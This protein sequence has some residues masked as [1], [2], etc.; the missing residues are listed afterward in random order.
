MAQASAADG[1]K[2]FPPVFDVSSAANLHHVAT[3]HVS[4]DCALDFDTQ[5]CAGSVTLSLTRHDL[6]AA[7]VVLDVQEIK[8]IKCRFE[9]QASDAA[10]EIKP[11]S[12]FGQALHVTL[13]PTADNELKLTIQF[14]GGETAG[15][16]WLTPEQTAGKKM[17]FVY[18]QGQACLNRSWFPCQDTPALKVTYDATVR[19]KPGFQVVMSGLPDVPGKSD[20]KTGEVGAVEVDGQQW[21]EF[22]Y[23]QPVPI[24]VYLVALAAGDLA[25]AEIGPRS[26]VWAEPSVLPAA[27]REFSEVTEKYL[28]TAESLFGPYVWGRYDL[29]VMPPSFPYGGMENPNLTFVTPTLLAGDRSLTD[30]I[31]H[32]IS[33]SWFGNLVTN[34][35]WNDF[36]LNEGFTTYAQRRICALATSPEHACLE[37]MS[38]IKLLHNDI[39]T[40]PPMLTKLHIPLEPGTDPDDTYCYTPYEKGFCFLSYLASKV[41]VPEFD[42]F[43]KAYV[44]QF[45]N[46]CITHQQAL[47]FFFEKFPEQRATLPFEPGFTFQEWL[48][49]AG[50]PPFEPDF[51]A[52]EP[53]YRPAQA[54]ADQWIAADPAVTSAP[55]PEDWRTYQFV[56]FLDKLLDAEPL[57]LE[58]MDQLD[59][60]FKFSESKNCELRFRWSK[61]IV[62]ASNEARFD[63]VKQFLVDQGKQKFTI[64]LYQSMAKMS[65]ATK[66]LA[67]DVFA[68]TT[69]ALNVAVRARVQRILAPEASE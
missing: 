16:C 22:K 53:L 69:T 27:T 58:R 10:F 29:L 17:P 18:T 62:K 14:E 50:A 63:V 26:H 21:N 55:A 37:A 11:F 41:G 60:A 43:L 6:W 31:M 35:T 13:P 52:A 48:H 30:T 61:L 47:D 24:P 68:A 15:V 66:K 23:R 42:A 36:W 8:V 9:G 39:A 28:E 40:E 19:A 7:S 1:I 33:H 65:A 38:G 57:P 44:V 4:L 59:A 25:C 46:K 34:A 12:P 56:F 2:P 20:A 64:P 32:E 49:T 5:T 3:T 51:S 67:E 54:L 45:S